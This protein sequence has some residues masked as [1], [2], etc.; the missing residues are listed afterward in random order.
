MEQVDQVERPRKVSLTD[1]SAETGIPS[2]VLKR[3]LPTS[4]FKA[5]GKNSKLFYDYREAINFI[6]ENTIKDE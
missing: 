2:G 3:T 6:R 1:L 5:P 4:R